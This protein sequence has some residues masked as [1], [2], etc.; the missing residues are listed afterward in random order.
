MSNSTVW[1]CRI[2]CLVSSRELAMPFSD[3]RIASRAYGGHLLQ[4]RGSIV[5][6][7]RVLL[8]VALATAKDGHLETP[9]ILRWILSPFMKASKSHHSA[10]LNAARLL[11]PLTR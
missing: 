1:T 5:A 9:L 3:L 11:N 2:R 10:V 6:K 4:P 7:G 8:T